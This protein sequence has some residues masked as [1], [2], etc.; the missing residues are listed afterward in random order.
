MGGEEHGR[1]LNG[2]WRT[3]RLIF[4]IN[5]AASYGP[6]CFD[7]CEV[8]PLPPRIQGIESWNCVWM[9]LARRAEK[10]H[11]FAH[12]V[13]Y[14]RLAEFYLPDTASAKALCYQK[15]RT[16]FDLAYQGGEI[17]RMEVPFPG[18]FL[19]A[20]RL[21]A[22]RELAVLVIHGGYDSFMERYAFV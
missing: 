6:E 9:E 10:E 4:Q 7:L 11:R 14:Y 5:R 15:F 3:S 2:L 17:E 8:R 12:A 20:L 16:C 21:R 18:T 22:E 1:Y 19:P 13:S